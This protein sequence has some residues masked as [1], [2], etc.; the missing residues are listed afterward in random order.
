MMP[1]PPVFPNGLPWV[2]AGFQTPCT[3]P[4]QPMPDGAYP[5]TI[6]PIAYPT[7]PDL[8]VARNPLGSLALAA[9]S[10]DREGPGALWW[11]GDGSPGGMGIDGGLQL[12]SVF[13]I[14]ELAAPNGKLP[15]GAVL[16]KFSIVGAIGTTG[17]PSTLW[18][19]L[20]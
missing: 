19:R 18:L 3:S 13:R 16:Q 4:D 1:N 11:P 20:A 6:D 17:S 15:P 14:P 7:S 8:V 2:P 10:G 9:P 12:L 5:V